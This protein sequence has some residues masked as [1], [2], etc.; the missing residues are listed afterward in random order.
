MKYKQSVVR[1]TGTFTDSTRKFGAVIR[2]PDVC[3][4][5]HTHDKLNEPHL[6]L[7][8]AAK[9]LIPTVALC[10]TDIDPSLISYPIP[11]NDDSITSIHYFCSLIKQVVL[12]AKKKRQDIDNDP[13]VILK[14]DSPSPF[15]E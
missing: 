8:E 7:N 9:M 12:I 15:I 3:V 13:N 4:F 6:A 5:F 14:L 1:K 2:L 10:D 11:S